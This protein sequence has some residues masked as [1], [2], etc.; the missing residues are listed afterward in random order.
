M[1]STPRRYP[2]G[3]IPVDTRTERHWDDQFLLRMLTAASTR[4]D[5]EL[6]GMGTVANSDFAGRFPAPKRSAEVDEMRHADGPK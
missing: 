3:D 6:A 2:A 4:G 1:V 5:P